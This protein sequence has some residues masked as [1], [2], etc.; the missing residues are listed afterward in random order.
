MY[1]CLDNWMPPRQVC[2]QGLAS[3]SHP[4]APIPLLLHQSSKRHGGFLQVHSMVGSMGLISIS[5]FFS[6]TVLFVS[7][8]VQATFPPLMGTSYIFRL[9]YL[10]SKFKIMLYFPICNSY[11]LYSQIAANDVYM[12]IIQYT[13]FV[14]LPR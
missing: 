6:G 7:T 12:K 8:S 9:D 4:T 11:F 5:S 13:L 1:V 3:Y 14:D 10:E 2:R